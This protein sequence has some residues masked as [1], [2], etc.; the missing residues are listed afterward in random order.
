MEKLD[1]TK[2]ATSHFFSTHF[3][4]I[5]PYS[6]KILQ[7]VF[8]SIL[9]SNIFSSSYYMSHISLNTATSF[10]MD[11]NNSDTFSKLL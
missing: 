10:D 3:N 5:V 8:P 7:V 2:T 11:S 9:P 6:S 1:S 4:I